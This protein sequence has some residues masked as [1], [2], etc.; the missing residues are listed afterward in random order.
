VLRLDP[1]HVKA[2]SNRGNALRE[3]KRHS[4]A[5]ESYAA[6]LNIKPDDADTHVNR[7]LCRLLIGDFALGWPEYEWRWK[8]PSRIGSWRNFS[9][10]LWG[11]GKKHADDKGDRLLVW[12]EQGLG[13]QLLQLSMLHSLAQRVRHITVAVEPRLVPLVQRSFDFVK[14]I[15]YDRDLQHEPCDSQLPMGS[16]GQ[17][18]RKSW[19]DF[20][21][22]R[23]AYLIADPIR[24]QQLREKI[25]SHQPLACGISWLSKSRVSD[26]AKSLRLRDLKPLFDVPDIQFIDLQ[27]SDTRLERHELQAELSQIFHL[28]QSESSRRRKGDEGDGQ[29]NYSGAIP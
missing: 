7:S 19:Q 11:G 25:T 21:T 13:D 9:Q 17:Y 15:A 10:P 2:L 26:Q 28:P 29:V 27:Y 6:A 24:S 23:Q 12:G 14:T 20:P 1:N 3:L 4:E 16:L 5:L 18:L 8:T 22:G